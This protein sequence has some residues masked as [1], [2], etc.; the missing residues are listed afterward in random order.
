M[1]Q[2]QAPFIFLQNQTKLSLMLITLD[3]YFSILVDKNLKKKVIDS[4][5]EYKNTDGGDNSIVDEFRDKDQ[6][7]NIIRKEYK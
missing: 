7:S 3:Y 1:K 2:N 5:T 6:G 4:S